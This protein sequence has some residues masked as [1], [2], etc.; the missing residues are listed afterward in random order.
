MDSFLTG[1][2]EEGE[3]LI[4]SDNERFGRAAYREYRRDHDAFFVNAIVGR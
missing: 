2:A 1:S 3:V 4:C